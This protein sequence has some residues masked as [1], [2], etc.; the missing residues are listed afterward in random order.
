[1]QAELPPFRAR[2]GEQRPAMVMAIA[3]CPRLLWGAG[4]S[5][6]CGTF[7]RRRLGD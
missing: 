7:M 4:Y 1:M 3:M 6:K 2:P 5:G